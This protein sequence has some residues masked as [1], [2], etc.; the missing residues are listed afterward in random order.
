MES[1]RLNVYQMKNVRVVKLLDNSIVD[2][3]VAESITYAISGLM[4]DKKV[5]KMILDFTAV[6]FMASHMLRMLTDLQK[7]YRAAKGSLVICGLRGE[8]RKVFEICGLNKVLTI[9]KDEDDAL[10]ML[11]AFS[12]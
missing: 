12:S 3:K 9:A 8:L 7:Q 2:V 5:R 11:G 10:R 6:Q 4:E 1:K